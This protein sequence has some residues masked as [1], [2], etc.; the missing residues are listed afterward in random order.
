MSKITVG[1]KIAYA[2]KK[3]GVS[4]NDLS[5]MLGVDRQQLSR[6]ETGTRNPKRDTL[7]KISDL[8][9]IDSGY[10]SDFSNNVNLDLFFLEDE[11]NDTL[12]KQ[13]NFRTLNRSDKIDAINFYLKFMSDNDVDDVFAFTI[14][15]AHRHIFPHLYDNNNRNK[16]E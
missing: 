3:R 10:F 4:Q 13:S 1:E 8:L 9:K 16:D 14:R 2:R 15:T 11:V 12:P 6:W 5:Q 7:E